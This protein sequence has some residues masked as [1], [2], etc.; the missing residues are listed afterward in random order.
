[1][2]VHV[3]LSVIACLPWLGKF[4]SLFACLFHFIYLS[5]VDL[6]ACCSYT[7]LLVHVQYMYST[8]VIPGHISD[9]VAWYRLTVHAQTV[10]I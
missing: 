4:A 1:M 7:L 3:Y 10:T 8:T 9:L 2:Y 5:F 6:S